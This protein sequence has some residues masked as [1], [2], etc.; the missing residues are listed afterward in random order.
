MIRVL[1]GIQE[2]L[3][4]EAVSATLAE[5]RDLE[6]VATASDGTRVVQMAELTKPHVAVVGWFM[7]ILNGIEITRQITAES[8]PP[9]VIL[10]C[11]SPEGGSLVEGYRA[12]ALACLALL[13]PFRL[14]IEAIRQGAKGDHFVDPEA[15]PVVA[16]AVK[17]GHGLLRDTLTRRERQVLQ[18]I[19]EGYTSEQAGT[20]L[21]ISKKTVDRHR[22]ELMEKLDI[23]DVAGLTRYAV[24]QGVIKP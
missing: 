5:E 23:H 9:A 1:V 22:A 17:N 4:L 12:G 11:D 7:P 19:A 15:A 3:F 16:A 18:L 24:R 13:S 6:I 2:R 8:K 21:G 20:H 14:L 10:L